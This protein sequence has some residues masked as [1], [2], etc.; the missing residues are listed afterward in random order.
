M[1]KI[2]ITDFKDSI[3]NI[4]IIRRNNIGDMICAIPALRAIRRELPLAHITVLAGYLNSGIINGASFVDEVIIY[5]KGCGIYSNKYI[6]YWKLLRH[7]KERF[8]LAIALK[9]GFSSTMSLIT[10]ISRAKLRMGCTPEKWHPLQHCYNL[11]VKGYK[12]WKSMLH[13]DALLEF[14]KVIGIENS[15]KD[16]R[17][18]TTSDAKNRVKRF[19]IEKNIGAGGNIIVFNISNNKTENTWSA[20]RFKE[21]SDILAKQY[22]VTFIVTSAPSDRDKAVRLVKEINANAVYFKTP[23]VMDFAA[24]AEAAGLLICGEGGAMHVGSSVG[25]PTISLWG[26]NRTAKWTPLG[27]KQFVIKKGEHVNSILPGDIL[28]E[29]RKNNLLKK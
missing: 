20:E 14:I 15:V 21:T 23:D 29:V 27:E 24:I 10:L 26:K 7:R 2:G 13:V 5:K 18:E 9:I 19:F 11:P 4:L 17:I 28:E 8:D 1:K 3:R 6:G 16:I 22:K 12:K 25:T